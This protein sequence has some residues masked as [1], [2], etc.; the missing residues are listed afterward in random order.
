LFQQAT[1]P[2]L[3]QVYQRLISPTMNNLPK[4]VR[5]GFQRICDENNYAFAADEFL[6]SDN[7]LICHIIAVPHA[8]FWTPASIIINKKSPYRKL[9]I[10]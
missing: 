6:A 3:E 4:S 5:E 8:F 2:A 9:F 7:Q 1:D 10:H